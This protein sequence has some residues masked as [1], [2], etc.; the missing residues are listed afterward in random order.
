MA[1]LTATAT[2]TTTACGFAHAPGIGCLPCAL[3]NTDADFRAMLT[4][5][6]ASRWAG[7][8]YRIHTRLAAHAAARLREEAGF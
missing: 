6:I 1:T 3:A 4:A 8:R 5:A 2:A 7:A